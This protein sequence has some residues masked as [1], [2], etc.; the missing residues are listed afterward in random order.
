MLPVKVIPLT[1]GKFAI[2][3]SEDYEA[4]MAAG[5]WNAYKDGNNWYAKKHIVI[6]R[7][8]KGWQVRRSLR[9]HQFLTDFPMTDHI[10]R[11]GLDN[12]RVNL[13]TATRELNASNRRMRKDNQSGYVGV[14]YYRRYGRWVAHSKG[15]TIG[16]YKTPEDAAEAREF[17]LREGRRRHAAG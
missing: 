12:R 6:G 8:E 15:V 7:D 1:Q 9:L 17:F 14:S 16:Y 13:R 2:V 5:P 3:D 4:V 11:N 10:N